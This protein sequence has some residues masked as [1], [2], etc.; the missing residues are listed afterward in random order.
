VDEAHEIGEHQ[1]CGGI[2]MGRPVVPL[3]VWEAV[4]VVFS[5]TKCD[6]SG[7]RDVR[8]TFEDGEVKAVTMIGPAGVTL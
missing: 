6:Q 3:D 8:L 5:C 2:V 7:A 4:R 1:D